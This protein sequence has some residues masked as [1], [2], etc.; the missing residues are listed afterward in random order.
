MS[1]RRSPSRRGRRS[2]GAL[3]LALL[4]FVRSDAQEVPGTDEPGVDGAEPADSGAQETLAPESPEVESG[5]PGEPTSYVATILAL[6][7]GRDSGFLVGEDTTAD[8][9]YVA[10]PT[11]ILEHRP[12]RRFELTVGYDPEIER[13][14]EQS[15]LSAVHHAAAARL[16]FDPTRRS[17][18][19]ALAS[20]LHGEDPSRYLSDLAIVMPRGPFTQ[21]QAFTGHEQRWERSALTVQIG[22]AATVIEPGTGIFANGIDQSEAVAG[23]DFTQ[24]LTDHLEGSASYSYSRPEDRTSRESSLGEDTAVRGPDALQSALLGLRAQASSKLSLGISAGVFRGDESAFLGAAEIGRTGERFAISLR[25]DH[26]PLSF[27]SYEVQGGGSHAVGGGAPTGSVEDS[28]SQALSLA[29]SAKLGQRLRWE[30]LAWASHATLAQEEELDSFAAAS[31]LV[32]DVAHRFGLYLQADHLEQR[33]PLPV[34]GDYART[35][36]SLGLVIGISGPPS[37]WGI[38]REPEVLDG[39]FPGGRVGQ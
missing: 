31:R 15:E 2:L 8:T 24:Q 6:G 30:Q 26:G 1:T 27:G 14:A 29:F 22:Y 37:A 10:R 34:E 17:Q 18:I 28:V 38:R 21:T 39:L 36:V 32:F 19:F 4:L 33:G 16:R 20:Y 3:A 12:S 23:I 25:Y 5:E 7:G 35:R 9:L 11:F 13:F